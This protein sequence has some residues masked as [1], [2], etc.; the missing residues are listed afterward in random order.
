MN[1]KTS[2]NRKKITDQ[3]KSIFHTCKESEEIYS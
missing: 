2:V 1:K 3:V